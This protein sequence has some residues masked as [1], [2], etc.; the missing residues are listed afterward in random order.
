MSLSE[1]KFIS[2][3]NESP[4]LREMLKYLLNYCLNWLK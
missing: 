4:I 2:V 1:L 3:A